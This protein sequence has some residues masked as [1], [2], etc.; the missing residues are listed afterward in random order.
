MKSITVKSATKNY[1][2]F[3]EE[4]PKILLQNLIRTENAIFVIDRNVHEQYNV[5][6]Q[7]IDESK[8]A[9]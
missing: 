8:K 3:F 5:L 2:V 4:N 9:L 1:Q 6:F 7:T